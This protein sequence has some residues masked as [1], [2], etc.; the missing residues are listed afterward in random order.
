MEIENSVLLLNDFI[1][2]LD[3]ILQCNCQAQVVVG[4]TEGWF[5]DNDERDFSW[6]NMDGNCFYWYNFYWL[7]SV[8]APSTEPYE[9][10][11]QPF[12]SSSYISA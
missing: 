1:P 9:R 8:F 4:I 10:A 12:L 2:P 5:S 7:H 11:P 3:N 6:W